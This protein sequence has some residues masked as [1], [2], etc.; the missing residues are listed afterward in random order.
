[1]II[2]SF[3]D[4]NFGDFSFNTSRLPRSFNVRVDDAR[5]IQQFQLK[6]SSSGVADE[7]FGIASMDIT[8]QYLSEVR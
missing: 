7:F 2:F 6:L 8:Y 4:M 1:M 3:E 5:N